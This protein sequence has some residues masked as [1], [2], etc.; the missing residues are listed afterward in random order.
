MKLFI[1]VLIIISMA[2]GDLNLQNAL[3]SLSPDYLVNLS[4]WVIIFC[5]VI[6]VILLVIIFFYSRKSATHKKAKEVLA[7]L[8]A[9]KK[10]KKVLTPISQKEV[11][12]DAVY[13]R[14]IEEAKEK[15]REAVKSD[16]VV[17][18]NESK[19]MD[20]K[21][22][23]SLKSLL[24]KKF[25]P[26][27]ETQLGTKVNII[28]FSVKGGEFFA[29]TEVSGVKVMLSLDSG[30]KIFDYKKVKEENNQNVQ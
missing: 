22:E 11:L 21:D 15:L 1:P 18:K 7:S 25:K 13:D 29:L 12:S 9:I 27:I 24:I 2:D 20:S 6:V 19:R 16:G 30:G 23:T 4:L 28:D 26:K 14:K 10:G 8:D 17:V 5:A 3:P